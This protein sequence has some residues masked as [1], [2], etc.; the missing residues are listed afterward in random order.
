MTKR[1]MIDEIMALNTTAGPEFLARFQDDDLGQYL[2]HLQAARSPRL[3][4]DPHRFDKY[5]ATPRKTAIGV[6]AIA[7][8]DEVHQVEKE[9]LLR[10][11]NPQELQAA[12]TQ[13]QDPYV[14]ASTDPLDESDSAEPA[15]AAA[16]PQATSEII[17]PATAQAQD[18]A[19]RNDLGQDDAPQED[20]TPMEEEDRVAAGVTDDCDFQV[21][22]DEP[23]AAQ[24]EPLAAA[25]PKSN[26]PSRWRKAPAGQEQ[27][28]AA[29]AAEKSAKMPATDPSQNAAGESP[30]DDSD[31]CLF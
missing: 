7:A 12:A 28:V 11:P 14:P 17:P 24:K 1:Q 21:D 9:A 22:L 31:S 27:P 23:P 18:T 16:R 26:A 30:D 25:K 2:R 13:E 8:S 19:V 3:S 10:P 15:V 4:G 5:F 29:S 6:V 20:P